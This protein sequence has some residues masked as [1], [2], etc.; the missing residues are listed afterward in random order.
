M[1]E[2][3][4]HDRAVIVTSDGDFACLVRYL[5]DQHKLERVLSPD[6]QHCSALLKQAAR[7]RIDFLAGARAKTEYK[8]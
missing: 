8:R 5:Y 6:A 3:P 7:E 2:Y 4:N 1:I